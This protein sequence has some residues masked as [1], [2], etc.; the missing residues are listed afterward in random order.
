[1]L[2]L[3]PLFNLDSENNFPSFFSMLLLL[4]ASLLLALICTFEKQRA[5]LFFK[6][7]IILALGF[8]Y[9]AVDE[10]ISLHESLSGPLQTLFGKNLPTIFHWTWVISGI[11]IVILTAIYFYKFVMQLPR[12]TAK[13]FVIAGFLYV[14]GAIGM[15]LVGGHYAFYWGIYSLEYIVWAIIEESLEIAGLVVFIFGLL[16]YIKDNFTEIKLQID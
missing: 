12:R 8:F 14:S 13:I 4:F 5:N 3:I 10:I 16:D 9:M 6:H 11:F 7:W 15:E 2:G 1:M